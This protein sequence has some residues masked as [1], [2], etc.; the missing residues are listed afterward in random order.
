MTARLT[1]CDLSRTAAANMRR[2]R[3][4][5]GW[6]QLRLAAKAKFHPAMI[7]HLE[8]GKRDFTLP[9]LERVAEALGVPA[10]ELLTDPPAG[11]LEA[12]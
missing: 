11:A 1:T 5:A 9:T 6:S 8:G 12:G 10:G 7:S 3:K 2:L 4:E